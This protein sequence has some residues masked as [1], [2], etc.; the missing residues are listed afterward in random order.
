MKM[1]VETLKMAGKKFPLG[2]ILR[3]SKVEKEVLTKDVFTMLARHAAGDWGEMSEVDKRENELSLNRGYRLMSAYT[4][5]LGAKLWVITEADRSVT[6]VLF[7][8]E[9]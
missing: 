9:Y 6:T 2:M 5:S 3:T 7:P 4:D 1:S 8:E